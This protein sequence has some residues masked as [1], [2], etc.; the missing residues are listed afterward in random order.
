[1]KAAEVNTQFIPFIITFDEEDVD[2]VCSQLEV[3]LN[4]EYAMGA[5]GN[6]ED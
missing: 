5:Y 1:M 4:M 2:Q 3:M 6:T